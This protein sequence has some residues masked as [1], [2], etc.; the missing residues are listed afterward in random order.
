MKSKLFKVVA[1]VGARPQFIKAAGLAQALGSQKAG[2]CLR[3]IWAHTGQHYDYRLSKIF[4]R[5]F[6]LPTPQVHLGVGSGTHAAQT[7]RMMEDLEKVFLKE[8]PRLVVV[9]GDT[10]STLAAAVA[11][12]KLQIP[13]A[14]IEAGLR[15]FNRA[16]PEETNRVLT[17]QVSTLLFCPTRGAVRQLKKEGIRKGVYFVGD[18][19]A[20]LLMS[21]VK[22]TRRVTAGR[23]RRAYYL[24]TI[25]RNTNTDD[26]ERLYKIFKA[27][28]GLDKPVLF[29]IHPRTRRLIQRDQRILKIVKNSRQ[30]N[31][32]P[33]VS[34]FKMISLE[35]NAQ[36]IITD[37]GGIQKEAFLLN[38]PCITL[39]RETEWPETVQYGRN[40]LCPPDAKKIL[41]AFEAIKKNRLKKAPDVFGEGKAVKKILR[42]I[43]DFLK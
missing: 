14:H 19:M 15:S 12:A 9:F 8:K 41:G 1:V 43:E 10:N 31:I 42:I 25:H 36:G 18:V 32:L 38:V 11:A 30:L 26:P 34:Y 4:F 5:E 2:G 24:A 35:Q 40:R 6:S 16:L 28:S 20:D 7:G 21:V 17:D 33:P 29:P 22:K 13:I 3:V 23:T 39:R 37:S 27:L